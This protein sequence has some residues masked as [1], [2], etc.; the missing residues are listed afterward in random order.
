MT[1]VLGWHVWFVLAFFLFAL[2]FVA[3]RAFGRR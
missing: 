3:G 2:I 1:E